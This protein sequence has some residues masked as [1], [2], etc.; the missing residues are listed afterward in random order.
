MR[1]PALFIGHGSPMNTLESNG[2]TQGWAAIG[3]NLPK[4]KAI[5]AISAHW[6][7]G[8]T[9]VTAMETPRT[10]HDFYGFPQ[11]LFDVQYPASG[12]PELAGRIQELVKPQWMGLDRDQWGLDHGT[13]SV[14]KHMYPEADVPVV[15][16]SLNAT[17]PMEYHIDLGRKLAALRDEGVMILGSGNVVHNLGR[18]EWDKPNSGTN[19]GRRFDDAAQEQLDNAP[20]DILKLREHPDYSLAVPTPDHFLPL[21]YLAGIAAQEG[22]KIETLQQ[23]HALGSISMTSYGI[24][25]KVELAKDSH[26]AASLPEDVPPEQSNI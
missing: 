13:W 23:G 11:E 21:L 26:R 17:Q 22:S 25:A 5:L 14:L 18:V 12:D 24:D 8:T 4:P 19:W 20:E 1:Q 7:F 10:I 2:Y 6:Y 15:Q 3:R 9:A 16:L